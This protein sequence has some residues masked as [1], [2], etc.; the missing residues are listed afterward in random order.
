VEL[1]AYELEAMN[2]DLSELVDAP[3]KVSQPDSLLQ[4]YAERLQADE[5][6]NTGIVIQ[7]VNF[8]VFYGL[9]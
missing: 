7:S 4:Q 1:N 8:F 6:R 3:E 2:V 5:H 9:F